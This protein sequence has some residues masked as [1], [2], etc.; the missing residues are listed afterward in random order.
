MVILEHSAQSLAT[1]DGA[2]LSADSLAGIDELVFQ[3]LVVPFGVVMRQKLASGVAQGVFAK[4]N[5]PVEAFYFNRPHE[6]LQVSV[7]VRRS[8]RQLYRLDACAFQ[9]GVKLSREFSVAVQE[10]IAAILEKTI[11]SIGQISGDLF[12][13]RFIRVGGATSKA[14]ASAGQLHHEQQV[15]GNQPALGPYFDRGKVDRP[16][17][18][19]VRFQERPP[20]GQG[21]RSGAGSTPCSLRMV[22]TVVSEISWPKLAR[23][24]WIRS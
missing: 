20:S 8:R 2:S 4:E 5:Q 24:P 21:F 13:P 3:T 9:Q 7:Q 10:E 14:D 22:P 15:E 12:H 18:V 1:L 23:A 16:E 19:P 17:N 6:P 11:L